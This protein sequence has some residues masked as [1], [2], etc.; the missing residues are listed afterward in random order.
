M[1][2]SREQY[3][4]RL[5]TYGRIV[6]KA[7]QD[8]GFKQRLLADPKATL[9]AEGLSFPEGAEVHAVETNDQLVYFPIPPKPAGL[10]P[11]E[12]SRMAGGTDTALSGTEYT[13]NPFSA[14]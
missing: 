5:K 8:D 11:E 6:A 12:L 14:I 9:Q 1:A 7:W 2:M 10:S 13:Y 4:E 3:E